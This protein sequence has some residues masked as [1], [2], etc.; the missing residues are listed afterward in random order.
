MGSIPAI[1][2]ASVARPKP[3][4]MT[5]A[6]KP[7][8]YA[9]LMKRAE[10]NVNNTLSISDLKK[11]PTK[12]KEE[13][14]DYPN[15]KPVISPM[16]PIRI[17]STKSDPPIKMTPSPVVQ[18]KKPVK[19]IKRNMQPRCQASNLVTLNQNKRDLRSI[20]QIQMELKQESKKPVKLKGNDVIKPE[21]PVRS[22]IE[23]KGE[24]ANKT[25]KEGPEKYYAKNY[26]SIISNIFGYNRN[27]YVDDDD[28]DLDMEV[29]YKTVLAEEARSTR[30]GKEE[31]LAEEM[32][33]HERKKKKASLLKRLSK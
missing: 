5:P 26:S 3:K 2:E 21:K 4:S 24:K 19:V 8:S 28:D 9:E 13:F 17:S 29:D 12:S 16:I 20:E 6:A 32:K 10:Q 31:D 14:K 27:K 18:K 33:E 25:E 30:L 15:P 22:E 1:A 23:S 11:E 7:L